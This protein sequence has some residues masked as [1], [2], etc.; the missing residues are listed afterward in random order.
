MLLFLLIPGII[1]VAVGGDAAAALEEAQQAIIQLF[2]Q[3]RC[4]ILDQLMFIQCAYVPQCIG[5]LYE[6][7][8]VQKGVSTLFWSGDG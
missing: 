4:H 8:I 5:R 3:I 6:Q 2:S 1:Q 7:E